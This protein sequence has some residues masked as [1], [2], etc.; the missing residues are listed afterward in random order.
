MEHLLCEER[1]KEL[2]VFILEKRRLCGDLIA[3]FQYLKGGHKKERDR[4]FS[5]VCCDRK[6]GNGFERKEGRFRLD[7][8]NKFLIIRVV[9]HWDKLP[10]EVVD[11]LF[12]ETF[13]ERLD[14]ALSNLI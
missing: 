14:Q 7:I 12:L 8:K 11:T 1:L 3:A 2:G 4:L 5:K 13:K 9:R 6:G 10:R